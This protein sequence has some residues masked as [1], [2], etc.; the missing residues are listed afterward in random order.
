MEFMVCIN[1]N[2]I[3]DTEELINIL[4]NRENGDRS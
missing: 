2:N 3:D 1:E 4:E